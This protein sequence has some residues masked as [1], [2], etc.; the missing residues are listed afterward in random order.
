MAGDQV[1]AVSKLVDGLNRNDRDQVLLGI[2]GSGKTFAM[3]NVI[4]K[5]NKPA[6]IMAHNKTLAA[7]LYNEMKSFFPHNAVE[8]FVSYYDYYQPEAYI[9]QTDTYIE[10]DASIN[11][12]IDLLRHSATKSL[13]ERR[14]VI[15]AASV[16]CIYGIG[17][18]ESY[19]AMTINVKSGQNYNMRDFLKQLVMLQYERNDI[20]LKRGTFRVAGDTVDLTTPYNADLAIRFS[21]FGDELEEICEIDPLLGKKLRI[22]KETT[23]YPASHFVTPRAKILQAIEEIKVDLADRL[24]FLKQ[25]GKLVEADRLEKRTNFDIEM[26]M[27][28]GGCRGIE[29]YS[30]YLSGREPGR[31][32]PTLLEY[33][34]KDAILFVDESHVTVPQINGMFRGDQARKSVLV[35]HGF[36]MP[37]AKDNRPLTFDEWDAMRPQTIYVSATPGKFELDLTKGIVVEQIIRPTGLLDPVCIVRSSTSQVDDLLREC[38]A[39]KTMNQRVLVT[40]LT[41]KMAEDL[42]QYMQ[43]SN[44]AVSYLHSDILTLDR[45][46]ILQDLRL[47]KFDVLVG[48]NLLREGLD[49][50]E[51]ALVAILDADKQ[52]FLRS[53]TSLVQTIGRAAR[54]VD[55]RVICY[56]ERMTAALENALRETNRRR[57]IQIKYNEEHN[58]IPRSIIKSAKISVS[59]SLVNKASSS[60]QDV[61]DIE[62]G[63]S[64]SYSA[65]DIDL[66]HKKMLQLARGMR[67]EEAALI[68]DRLHVIKKKELGLE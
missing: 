45:I 68:R 22:L 63:S 41:K 37:S 62:L 11:E 60:A 65:K 25:E 55:G 42:C 66:L 51:C 7:Q 34:P 35:E 10:K 36:R 43:E 20:E 8:Y 27:E 58:I 49:I 56:A 26:L 31:P 9:P 64:E 30:R 2:T 39:A 33:F 5:T 46:D 23:I 32:P 53:E 59:E 16:S 47:G 3:A 50:P 21:F 15:V 1:A 54:N 57:S 12:Q 38:K 61:D 18:P 6:L 28:T 24:V 4:A 14:D 17:S 13:T 40:V 29:N 44:I 48:V 19:G 52:G 67:F